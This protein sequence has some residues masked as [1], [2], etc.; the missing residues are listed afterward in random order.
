MK[1]PSRGQSA[2]MI[3]DPRESSTNSE[4]DF[5]TARIVC[6]RV[7]YEIMIFEVRSLL[8]LFVLVYPL[9]EPTRFFILLA[10]HWD[11]P[12]LKIIHAMTGE[13]DTEQGAEIPTMV[14]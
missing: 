2:G 10:Y 1:P 11:Y 13:T 12:T 5:I 4:A 9:H 3:D 8:G 7:E 6:V 14:F